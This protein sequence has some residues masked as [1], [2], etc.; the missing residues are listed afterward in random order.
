MKLNEPWEHVVSQTYGAT[1]AFAASRVRS[2]TLDQSD[3]D[4]LAERVRHCNKKAVGQLGHEGETPMRWRRPMSWGN[5]SGIISDRAETH[6]LGA[7]E[8]ST[9]AA[10][11]FAVPGCACREE[12]QRQS[13]GDEIGAAMARSGR[14]AG[15]GRFRWAG[16]RYAPIS[17]RGRS[18]PLMRKSSR[19]RA[20]KRRKSSGFTT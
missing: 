5:I 1:G 20:L 19:M 13:S 3:P 15:M 10:R 8:G 12:M 2:S 4:G 18:S 6:P 7:L 16:A 11:M 14:S 9:C 17:L